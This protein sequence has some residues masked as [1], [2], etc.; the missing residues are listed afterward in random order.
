MFKFMAWSDVSDYS[1]QIACYE[2]S[3]LR[4]TTECYRRVRNLTNRE[5]RD[6]N[7]R[8]R[9]FW[10][11]MQGKSWSSSHLL[12]VGA[13]R[14]DATPKSKFSTRSDSD[15]PFSGSSQQDQLDN[16][17]LSSEKYVFLDLC[18]I[19]A[20]FMWFSLVISN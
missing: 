5:P 7:T 11:N 4:K 18:D 2:T 1:K 8:Y 10:T 16:S 15:V 20:S 12:D 14:F 13:K 9:C 3:D 6:R 19:W 17:T